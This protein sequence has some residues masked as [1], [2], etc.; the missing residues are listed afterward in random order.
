[1]RKLLYSILIGVI[2]SL[3]S[4]SMYD[5]NVDKDEIGRW[6]DKPIGCCYTDGTGS[7]T[8]RGMSFI[9]ELFDG[10]YKV[11]DYYHYGD[12]VIK[13]IEIGFYDKNNNLID[14]IFNINTDFIISDKIIGTGNRDI[15][16]KVINYLLYEEGYVRIIM[17]R[18]CM[19][20]WDFRIEC[21]N[22]N[23]EKID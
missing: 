16:C 23:R 8:I 1:M 5:N 17:S 20:P 6:V 2:V 7:I 12:V 18:Y 15:N 3:S 13:S 22:N 10:N 4:C 14:K 11:A 21:M 19:C 9:I